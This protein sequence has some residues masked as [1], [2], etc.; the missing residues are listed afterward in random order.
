MNVKS[1]AKKLAY[2]TFSTVWPKIYLPRVIYYHSVHPDNDLTRRLAP[3]KF[4]AQMQWLQNNHYDICTF[5]QLAKRVYSGTATQKSV[6]ITFDDGYL[7]NYKTVLPILLDY[8]IKATFF[9]ITSMIGDSPKR[10]DDGK[11]LCPSRYMMTKQ[12]LREMHNSGMEIGSHTQTHIHVR[13]QLGH[14]YNMAWNELAGSRAI[15]ENI[16]GDEVKTFC[17]P[18]GQ[19]G[20]FNQETKKLLQ[21]AGYEYAATTIWGAFNHQADPL[22][23]P[24][25]RIRPDDSLADFEKKLSGQYDFIRG[26]HQSRDGS[27]NWALAE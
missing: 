10:S 17:Y 12:Q 19:N 23:I 15:L 9:V 24:R 20:V 7:D 26:V 11:R 5:S 25:I 1:T 22:E 18:N 16:I 3:D 13:D 6:A 27:K 8:Q 2:K 21:D 4:L 14:S